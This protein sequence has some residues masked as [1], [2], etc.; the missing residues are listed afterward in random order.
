M[1]ISLA[2]SY[3]FH[4]RSVDDF[5]TVG[6]FDLNFHEIRWQPAGVVPRYAHGVFFGRDHKFCT[7]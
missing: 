7:V 2:P 4:D 6:Y 3:K 5:F 1:F